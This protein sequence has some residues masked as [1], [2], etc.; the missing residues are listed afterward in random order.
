MAWDTATI[1]GRF[2]YAH[3]PRTGKGHETILVYIVTIA[4]IVANFGH[5]AG[6]APLPVVNDPGLQTA[7]TVLGAL[8]ENHHGQP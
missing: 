3:D 8:F 4:V 7:I 1:L 5:A 2:L 6:L